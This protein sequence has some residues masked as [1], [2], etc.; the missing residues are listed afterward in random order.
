MC[1]KEGMCCREA[2]VAERQPLQRT[3][4]VLLEY[5]LVTGRNEVLAKVI[6]LHVC[7]IL[8]TG[9]LARFCSNFFGGVCSRFCSNFSGGFLQIFGGGS[10]KFSGGSFFGGVFSVMDKTRR[11]VDSSK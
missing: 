8:F 6:F 10:S 1:G 5:I 4:R 2:G 9:G 3:V 7:V 11:G